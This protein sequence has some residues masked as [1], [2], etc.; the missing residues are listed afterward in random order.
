MHTPVNSGGFVMTA[1]KALSA[2]IL[3]AVSIS[4]FV[5]DIAQ[6]QNSPYSTGSTTISPSTKGVKQ[7][8]GWTGP[9]DT[10]S[11]GAPASSPQ[12]QSPPNMQAAP[13]GSSKSIKSPDDHT[14]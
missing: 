6:A 14:Q 5:T 10:S 9:L 13:E 3:T 1:L 12:G 11:G 8:Q 4:L 7:P 2:A